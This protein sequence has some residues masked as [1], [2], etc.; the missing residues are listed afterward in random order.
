MEWMQIRQL[1]PDFRP[2]KGQGIWLDLYE[3]QKECIDYEELKKLRSYCTLHQIAMHMQTL[4][5]KLLKNGRQYH[6]PAA[7]AKEQAAKAKLE[8]VPVDSKE[9][10]ALFIRLGKSSFRTSF[11]LKK[12]DFDYIQ[13]KSLPAICSHAYDFL[14]TRLEPAFPKKD[15]KQTPTKGH[16]VFLAAHATATCCRGCLEKWHHIPKGKEL[17]AA[18]CSYIVQVQMAWIKKQCANAENKALLNEN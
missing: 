4:P 9:L 7:Y 2:E 10:K 16:P 8:V 6:I 11:S 14:H 13:Q 5:S 15:G 17:S 1:S 12:K 18:Q 3:E